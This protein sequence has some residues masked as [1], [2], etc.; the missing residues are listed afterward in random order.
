[1]TTIPTIATQEMLRGLNWDPKK[2]SMWMAGVAKEAGR[3]LLTLSQEANSCEWLGEH[4]VLGEP[5]TDSGPKEFKVTD[6]IPEKDV[7]RYVKEDDDPQSIPVLR[8]CSRSFHV[9][10]AG[11]LE[12]K[13]KT[14]NRLLVCRTSLRDELEEVTDQFRVFSEEVDEL[15]LMGGC[16]S[17]EDWAVRWRDGSHYDRVALNNW[18]EWVNPDGGPTRKSA[19]LCDGGYW[20]GNPS[21]KGVNGP[22][23]TWWELVQ[24]MHVE[25]EELRR[26]RPEEGVEQK[27]V[28]EWISRNKGDLD[29][30]MEWE[31]VPTTWKETSDNLLESYVELEKIC[32]N[33]EDLSEEFSEKNETI[34]AERDRVLDIALKKDKRCKELV[35]SAE[36]DKARILTLEK[37]NKLLRERVE[38][39]TIRLDEV[40]RVEL[41]CPFAEKDE[42]KG[43]GAAFDWTSKV[44]YVPAGRDL[45]P[46]SRWLH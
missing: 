35:T 42:A 43:L 28:A 8:W 10:L 27:D 20:S 32:S 4:S 45:A 44:W 24:L 16:G 2:K 13:D 3:S 19:W 14:I 6:W 11:M 1:M 5:P 21:W 23:K 34:A 12:T 31:S 30:L 17:P 26:Q 37:E 22:V 36:A 41:R 40:G 9:G 46:F 38:K 15:T 33:F 29:E 39:M 7:L 18:W 25:Y